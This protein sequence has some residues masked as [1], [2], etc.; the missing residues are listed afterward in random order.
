MCEGQIPAW[1]QVVT[2]GQKDGMLQAPTVTVK[3]NVDNTLARH[4]SSMPPVDPTIKQIERASR[5]MGTIQRND[6]FT[7]T[8]QRI[9]QPEMNRIGNS[10][11]HKGSLRS[12]WSAFPPIAQCD[13]GCMP[14]ARSDNGGNGNGT[15]IHQRPTKL[16]AKL[17][18]RPNED[19]VRKATVAKRPCH[20]EILPRAV[21]VRSQSATLTRLYHLEKARGRK[22]GG[23]EQPP[24]S[25][26]FKGRARGYGCP[27]MASGTREQR[28]VC[29]HE[30]LH[31]K[32]PSVRI[33]RKYHDAI[34]QLDIPRLTVFCDMTLGVSPVG[35]RDGR[36]LHQDE[37]ALGNDNQAGFATDSNQFSF[38][39]VIVIVIAVRCE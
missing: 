38:N 12:S 27:I 17:L 20:V 21:L 18:A 23:R 3:L 15:E 25:A 1:P 33:L 37:A 16:W 5:R 2:A 14:E 19:K 8:A 31:L 30:E 34:A 22:N 24:H 35:V 6:P 26:P 7:S 13:T 36:K 29:Q 11:G 32:S 10:V 28:D 9:S 39:Q 4:I